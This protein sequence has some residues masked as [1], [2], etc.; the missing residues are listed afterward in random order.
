MHNNPERIIRQRPL[1]RLGLIPRRA[2][3]DIAPLEIPELNP[4][5]PGQYVACHHPL[6]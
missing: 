3:P 4:I 5:A 1:Q 6:I 2:H